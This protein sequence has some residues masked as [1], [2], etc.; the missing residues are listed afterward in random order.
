MG[1]HGPV[2]EWG[3]PPTKS[4]CKRFG[5]CLS[6]TSLMIFFSLLRLGR[7][8]CDGVEYGRN[9]SSRPDFSDSLMPA[10]PGGHIDSCLVI[11]T[12][13]DLGVESQSRNQGDNSFWR[14]F[15]RT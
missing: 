5:T 10:L 6:S 8:V 4:N 15:V 13:R 1:S 12:F 14:R 2:N 11:D 3:Y 9:A 7:V